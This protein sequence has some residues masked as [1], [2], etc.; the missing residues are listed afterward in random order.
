[1]KK[2]VLPLLLFPA[3]ASAGLQ[4]ITTPI[5]TQVVLES[6]SVSDAFFSVPPEFRFSEPLVIGQWIRYSDVVTYLQHVAKRY[7]FAT[8][9][10]LGVT[11]MNTDTPVLF[12]SKGASSHKPTVYLQA[13]VHGDEPAVTDATIKVI[14]EIAGGELAYLL[15]KLDIAIVPMANPDGARLMNRVTSINIDVNRTY[16][17]QD[18]PEVRNIIKYVNKIGASVFIDAH[19]FTPHRYQHSGPDRSIGY[20]AMYAVSNNWNLPPT[21]QELNRSFM[22]DIGQYLDKNTTIRHGE[23][24]LQ[25]SRKENEQTVMTLNESTPA[26]AS[27]KNA[28][29]MANRVSVLIE[30]RGIKLGNQHWERRV[31][32][33]YQTMV[34]VLTKTARDSEYILSALQKSGEQV[35]AY[36]SQ[37]KPMILE[38]TPLLSEHKLRYPMID[39]KNIQ[40]TWHDYEHWLAKAG[41]VT[42][43]RS[44]PKGYVLPMHFKDIVERLRNHGVKV[45]ELTQTKS[46]QVEPLL[47]TEHN[48]SNKFNY[49]TFENKVQVKA[50]PTTDVE[51]PK[52]TFVIDTA[53]P[54]A[55]YLLSLEPEGAASFIRLGKVPVLKDNIL[56]VYRVMGSL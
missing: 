16:I 23:Y 50:L 12:L 24:V 3:L 47:V 31:N 1:M 25:N 30:G 38:T 15:D 6:P 34:A 45:D 41:K 13:R 29:G 32:A 54:N 56:P 43:E 36:A 49:G 40:L 48:I 51:F 17:H 10:T 7:D 52:G 20:D 19:E 2:L 18:N 37:A 55:L 5:N 33:M 39:H 46:F 9:D 27:A 44:M 28:M 21:L 22:E 26:F 14:E 11:D 42:A 8:L 35:S 53:Q 4:H